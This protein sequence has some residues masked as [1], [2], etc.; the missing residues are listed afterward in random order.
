V[1][2]IWGSIHEEV[3]FGVY[4]LRMRHEDAASTIELDVEEMEWAEAI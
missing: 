4:G 3:A 2:S 1:S